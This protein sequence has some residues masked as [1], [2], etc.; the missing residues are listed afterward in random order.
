MSEQKPIGSRFSASSTAR[1]VTEGIDLSGKTAI[2]TGGYSGLGVETT[3]ALVGAALLSSYRPEIA[4]MAERTLAGI[5]NVVI[6]AMDL[7]DPASV[8]AFAGKIVAAGMP[9][10][11]LVNSAGIM[12]DAACPGSGWAREPIRH[13]SSRPFPVG[14]RPVAGAGQG[15][16]RAGGLCVVARPSNRSGRFRRH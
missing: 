11:I 8:A 6:E 2:V 1:E 5:D 16:Q 7:A 9:I 15:W 4:K 14:C 10:S 13:Q 3:R 12:A